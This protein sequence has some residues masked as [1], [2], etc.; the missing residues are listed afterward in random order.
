MK[1]IKNT[2]QLF[3]ISFLTSI[4]FNSCCKY[5]GNTLLEIKFENFDFSTLDSVML[6]QT[7]RNNI[8]LTIDTTF[9]NF[10]TSQS[11]NIRIYDDDLENNSYVIKNFSPRLEH[12]ITDVNAE[13]TKSN[14]CLGSKIEYSFIY[15]GKQYNKKKNHQPIVIE[16]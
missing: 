14:G 12:F 15:N 1:K 9:Y 13:R 7:D 8:T 16:Y 5:Q 2:L 3:L 11:I 10:T 6:I 4:L